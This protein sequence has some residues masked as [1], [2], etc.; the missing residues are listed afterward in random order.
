MIGWLAAARM[1][2]AGACIAPWQSSFSWRSGWLVVSSPSRKALPPLSDFAVVAAC[3]G[4]VRE[5]ARALH[6]HRPG[7][8]LDWVDPGHASGAF[9]GIRPT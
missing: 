6:P 8:K 2:A 9:R 7:S 1:H 5:S 4:E 3:R